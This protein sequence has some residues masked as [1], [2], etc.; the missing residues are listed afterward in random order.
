M[1]TILYLT[2]LIL[3]YFVI[4][5]HH[6][7]FFPQFTGFFLHNLLQV[8]F[9]TEERSRSQTEDHHKQNDQNNK[10]CKPEPWRF[11]KGWLNHE[12]EFCRAGFFKTFAVNSQ[13]FKSIFSFTQIGKFYPTRSCNLRP[14]GVAPFEHI[15]KSDL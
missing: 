2:I 11:P 3:N 15:T 6:T 1:N 13:Y 7:L 9:S 4:F 12:T 10:T 14:G 5:F 8:N